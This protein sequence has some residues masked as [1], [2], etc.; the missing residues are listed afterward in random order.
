M[1]PAETLEIHA[2]LARSVHGLDERKPDMIEACFTAG[3]VFQLDIK[4][5]DFIPPFE[6]RDSIMKLMIDSMNSHTE[7]RRHV[8]SNIFF[9]SE[10]GHS[11]T[12]VS[13]LV[14]LQAINNTI[15]VMTSGVYRDQLVLQDGKWLISRR[16]LV[17]DVPY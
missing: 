10:S 7:D 16:H 12:A 14:A 9:E 8:L 5:A 6:G 13:T 11:V 4:G 1:S 2:M 15:G 17:L 3:A